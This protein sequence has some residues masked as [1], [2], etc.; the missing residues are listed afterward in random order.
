MTSHIWRIYAFT[1][2]KKIWKELIKYFQKNFSMHLP[3]HQKYFSKSIF[4][5]SDVIYEW[6]LLKI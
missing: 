3:M 6:S 1:P 2:E 4:Y 5:Q